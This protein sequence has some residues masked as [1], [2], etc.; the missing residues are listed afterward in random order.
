MATGA[1]EMI[2]K[3]IFSGSMSLNDMEIRRRPYH[4]NCKCALHRSKAGSSTSFPQPRNILFP[5]KQTWRDCSLSLVTYQP[6]VKQI[7]AGPC[8]TNDSLVYKQRNRES[9][10]I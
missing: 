1:A 5:E 7:P 3:C 10:T 8:Y 4:R 2:L 9:E 6:R